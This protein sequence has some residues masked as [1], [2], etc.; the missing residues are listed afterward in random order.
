MTTVRIIS[1]LS[2]TVALEGLYLDQFQKVNTS[3]NSIIILKI[4]KI[5]PDLTL[6]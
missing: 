1:L 5:V 6:N 2:I 3:D 4:N